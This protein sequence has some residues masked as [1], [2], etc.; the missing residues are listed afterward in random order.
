[1]TTLFISDLHLDETRP[2][3]TR[4]FCDFLQEKAANADA[5]YILGDFFEVWLGDDHET[6]FN[7]HIISA[8][9]QLEVPKYVMHGNRDF[10]LGQDFC[11]QTGATLLDD[12]TVIE[13][14]GRTLLLMHGDSLCTRDEAYMAVRKQLRDSSFQQDFLSKTIAERQIF[15]DSARSQSK[16][17]TR[18]VASDIMD[19]TPSEVEKVM[20]SHGVKTMIHGHTHR[21]RTHE[22]T[23][24]GVSAQRIVLGDW[25][26]LGWYLQINGGEFK[27]QSFTINAD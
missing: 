25:D 19:V 23:L 16:E 22:L 10:L 27:L 12:P 17:H 11:Q 15:A 5:L 7:R 14:D 1:M 13:I 18:E 2:G 6:A 9:K 20:R 3:I 8:L 24:D 26:Q 21:P 4:A